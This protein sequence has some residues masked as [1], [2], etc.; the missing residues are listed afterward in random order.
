MR[1]EEAKCVSR[2]LTE[3]MLYPIYENLV[4]SFQPEVLVRSGGC[5][6]T[7]NMQKQH[8]S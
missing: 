1:R 6:R 2:V 3:V 7:V 4:S 5:G 8:S